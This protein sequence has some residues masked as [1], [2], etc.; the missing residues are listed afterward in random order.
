MANWVGPN[1]GDHSSSGLLASGLPSE[2]C[3]KVSPPAPLTRIRTP[4]SQR[5]RC[6]LHHQPHELL[7]RTQLV[8]A[9]A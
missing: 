6:R 1:E 7:H 2:L 5:S 3:R 9:S 4:P 8:R